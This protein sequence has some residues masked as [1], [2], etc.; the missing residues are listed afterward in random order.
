MPETRYG[1]QPVLAV[2]R[3]TRI[4]L[5]AYVEDVRQ[6][7]NDHPGDPGMT[8]KHAMDSVHGLVR[9]RPPWLAYTVRVF[10]RPADELWTEE[11]LARPYQARDGDPMPAVEGVDYTP[12]RVVVEAHAGGHIV[13]AGGEVVPLAD[14]DE[15]RA[16]IAKIESDLEQLQPRFVAGETAPSLTPDIMREHVAE[17]Q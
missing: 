9:P 14:P 11:V 15:V 2:I 1:E 8:Y 5:T 13:R 4:P 12:G 3:A 17:A 16:V 10:G 6:G 7:D